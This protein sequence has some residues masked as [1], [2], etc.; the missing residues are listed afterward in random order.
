MS[1]IPGIN[2]PPILVT[3]FDEAS[4]AFNQF[5]SN[6]TFDVVAIVDPD[7]GEQLFTA[8]ESMKANIG[9]MSKIMDHPLEDGSPVSDYKII[10]P[11]S[12][13]LG[14]LLPANDFDSTYSQIYDSFIASDFLTVRTNADTYENMVIEGLPHDETPDMYGMLAIS[15][16]LREVQLITVQYQALPPKQVEQPTDASTVDRGEQQPQSSV[17]FDLTKSFFKSN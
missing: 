11:I 14:L 12:I 17:L 7:T 5:N 6:F 4:D 15:L 10:L 2:V 13:E 8:A 9:P 16:R 3:A 1:T